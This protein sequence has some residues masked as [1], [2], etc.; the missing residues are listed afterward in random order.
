[1]PSFSASAYFGFGTR[2]ARWLSRMLYRVR[3]H[4]ASEDALRAIDPDATVI[5]VMNHR[6]NMD[7]VLV[8]FL[9]ADRTT[10]SYAVGEWAR[11]WP[12]ST[13]IRS[14]GAYFIRR[15]SRNAL[16]RRVLSRYVQIATAAGVAQA[17]FPEGGLSLDG[18]VGAPKLGILSYITQAETIGRDV[19]FVPVAINYDRVI[20][21][22]FLLAALRRGERRFDVPILRTAGYVMRRLWQ[23]LTG[24]FLRYGYAAVCFGHPLSLEEM[25]ATHAGELTEAVAVEL[26]RRIREQ[27]PVLPVPLLASLLVTAD[28]MNRN[29]LEAAFE[30]RVMQL[31]AAG[32]YVN[33]P[34]GS[35]STAMRLALEHLLLRRVLTE[36]DGDI[37][38]TDADRPLLAYYAASI[39]HHLAAAARANKVSA[40]AGS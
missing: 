26:M 12:L 38:V 25:R 10:L 9:A 35:P 24:R 3:V 4:V 34:R 13:L 11:V 39:A 28:R 17:V 30:E 14:M 32:V 40:V 19:V 16:Y 31:R 22:R 1:V 33:A 7:Y 29:D 21:D 18:T 5:F 20:E 37:V 23:K 6:S 27:V 36:S 2:A 15:R 8:T